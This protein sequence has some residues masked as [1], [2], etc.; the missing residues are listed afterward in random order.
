MSSSSTKR[1]YYLYSN[2]MANQV[3]NVYITAEKI[4]NPREKKNGLQAHSEANVFYK[5]VLVVS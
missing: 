4:F 3:G 1:I 5:N 2:R